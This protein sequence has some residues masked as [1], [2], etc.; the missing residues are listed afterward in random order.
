MV[1]AR[2]IKGG[3]TSREACHGL[4]WRNHKVSQQDVVVM[5]TSSFKPFLL[6]AVVAGTF[7]VPSNHSDAGGPPK[8]VVISRL[9]APLRALW[10]GSFG[11]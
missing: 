4:P 1:F 11:V 3:I 10:A 7:C 2:Q 5:K 8:K 6:A 9:S